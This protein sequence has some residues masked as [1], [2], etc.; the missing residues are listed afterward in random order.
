MDFKYMIVYNIE[1]G[2]LYF[3]DSIT[4]NI[5][6]SSKVKIGFESIIGRHKLINYTDMAITKCGKNQFTCNDGS[7]ISL[8]QTCDFHPDCL[9]HSDEAYCLPLQNIPDYYNKDLSGAGNR[10]VTLHTKIY[11][12]VDISMEDGT[13][14]ID[15][16]V[17]AH[18]N[19]HRLV[20]H[21]IR[22]NESIRM[23]AQQS[24][25]CWQPAIALKGV[26]NSDVSKLSMAREPG[27]VKISAH[28]KGSPALFRSREGKILYNFFFIN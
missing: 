19:D 21:N 9:D 14:T 22:R 23:M 2:T 1:D 20:F 28:N 16:L 6:W 10:D 8:N 4:E 24:K 25:S 26:V 13:V 27:K 12:I 17:D 11:Q 3:K 5:L 15:F 7:C 18:W